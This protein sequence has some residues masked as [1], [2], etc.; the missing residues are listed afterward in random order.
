MYVVTLLW[1]EAG[2]EG[3]VT[4]REWRV[5]LVEFEVGSWKAPGFIAFNVGPSRLF[6]L[7]LAGLMSAKP[8]WNEALLAVR[9]SDW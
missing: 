4:E 9:A 7:L 1:N 5:G 6:A 2:A 8:F 3:E